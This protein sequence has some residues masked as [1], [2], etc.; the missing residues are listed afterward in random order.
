ML[1]GDIS[2]GFTGILFRAGVTEAQNQR[3]VGLGWFNPPAHIGL[4]AVSCPDSLCMETT[5]SS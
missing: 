5:Q 3:I 2:V 4:P 1:Y